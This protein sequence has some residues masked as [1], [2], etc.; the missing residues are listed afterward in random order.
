MNIQ[1]KHYTFQIPSWDQNEKH[2]TSYDLTVEKFPGQTFKQEVSIQIWT[3]VCFVYGV[4]PLLPIAIVSI[5]MCTFKIP[6]CSWTLLTTIIHAFFPWSN[7]KG[8]GHH[9][10]ALQKNPTIYFLLNSC[11]SVMKIIYC[12]IFLKEPLIPPAL[13]P[14]NI[15]WK[16][17]ATSK[18]VLTYTSKCLRLWDTLLAFTFLSNSS[19]PSWWAEVWNCTSQKNSHRDIS[20]TVLWSPLIWGDNNNNDIPVTTALF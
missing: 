17:Y 19:L 20:K 14:S 18:L 11:Q 1:F 9:H 4:L 10:S 8:R 13:P 12:S 16:P 7:L 3:V 6:S 15:S 5:S 2:Q